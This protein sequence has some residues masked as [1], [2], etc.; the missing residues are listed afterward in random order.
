MFHRPDPIGG[1][2]L[3]CPLQ[4]DEGNIETEDIT[5]ESSDVGQGVASIGYGEYPV[6]HRDHLH[7]ICKWRD[8]L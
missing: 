7:D 2:G 6:H 3:G 8:G 5:R 1:L 4:V